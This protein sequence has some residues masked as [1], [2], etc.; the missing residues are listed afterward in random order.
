MEDNTQKFVVSVRG[1]LPDE[2]PIE[3][4]LCYGGC[5]DAEI[6]YEHSGCIFL[7]FDREYPIH[8]DP[9]EE[10]LDQVQEAF[11][12]VLD[13]FVTIQLEETTNAYV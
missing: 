10:A 12:D 9:T 3:D 4:R 7:S 13:T 5:A 2:T 8:Q 1:Q 11:C 6:S